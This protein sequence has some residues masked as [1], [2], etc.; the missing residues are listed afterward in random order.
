MDKK[1]SSSALINNYFSPDNNLKSF[2][3]LV[4]KKYSY[5]D[6]FRILEEIKKSEINVIGDPIIDKYR[7]GYIYKYK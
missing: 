4:K 6:V 3:N 2:I 7:Y 1:Y 5:N